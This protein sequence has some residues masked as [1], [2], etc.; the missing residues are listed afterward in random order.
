VPRCNA[1]VRV[2]SLAAL[3]ALLIGAA[4]CGAGGGASSETPRASKFRPPEKSLLGIVWERNSAELARLDARTLAPGSRRATVGQGTTIAFSPNG[5]TIALASTEQPEIDLVDVE[6]LRSLGTVELGVPGYVSRL[7]WTPPG[8]LFVAVGQQLVV[9]IDPVGRK[10]YEARQ[11]D[12]TLIA[13]Q[14]I[15]A[16]LLGLVAPADR[17]GPLKL[18]VWGGKG[19]A[20][21]PLRMVGGWETDQGKDESDF[22]AR[23][24]VPGLA[25]QPNGRRALVVSAGGPVAEVDLSNLGV[26]Y[27]TLS[28]P[29]SLLHRLL[30]WLDPAAEAKMIEGKERQAVWLTNGLIAVS[31]VDYPPIEPGQSELTGKPI[32]LSLIDTSDWSIRTIDEKVE[33]VQLAGEHLLGFE[34]GCSGGSESLA[35]VGYDLRGKERFRF[36]RNEGF[37]PV[38]VGGY[39]YV[40]FDDNTRFEVHDLETGAIVARLRTRQTTTILVDD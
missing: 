36:C 7:S 18:V 5:E 16:G 15:K 38:V 24:L 14:P 23:E 29:V 30:G 8:M 37:D 31:G 6:T 9:E 20:S 19:T 27:H 32:G 10:A 33:G 39:A 1:I 40:G 3:F 28:E 11:V 21:V 26:T 4:A 13:A 34:A 22:R 2:G 35:L 25:V 12:G 17:I